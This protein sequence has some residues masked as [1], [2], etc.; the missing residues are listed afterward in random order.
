MAMIGRNER[1]RPMESRPMETVLVGG[2]VLLTDGTLQ[3]T[4]VTLSGGRIVAI[5]EA[6]RSS[7]RRWHA[8]GLLVLP[9]MVDL[10]GDAFE[11]Q[12]MPRP[13]VRFPD[14]LALL[15]TDRQL[16]ANGITT[17]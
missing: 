14:D 9:G 2:R 12:L 1:K 6:P 8:P 11:R 17:A 7:A 3:E 13:G 16:L 15:D 5:G 10:H 4:D